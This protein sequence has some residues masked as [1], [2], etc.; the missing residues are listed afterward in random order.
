VGRSE[1]PA[2]AGAIG[3]G[4]ARRLQSL[5]QAGLTYTRDA[6]DRERYEELLRIA[7]EMLSTVSGAPPGVVLGHLQAE[8]GYLTPKVDVRAVVVRDERIL[9]VRETHDG[10]WSLPGGWAD[11]GDSPG[12]AAARE[13]REESGYEVR[14]VKLLAV[15]DK[16]RQGMQP[17]LWATYKIFLR[18]ALTGGAMRTSIE[19]DAVGFFAE[20]ALPPLSEGRVTPAQ[21][22]RMFEHLRRPDL[23]AD[24]D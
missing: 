9:L 18:C 22:A 17:G 23:P 4:R 13:V 15:Y 1:G 12:E 5:A 16:D 2:S 8:R 6:Y 21:I 19:T 20:D 24:F 14:P 7:A 10:R 3:L 11:V